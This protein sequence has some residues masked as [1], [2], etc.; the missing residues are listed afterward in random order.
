MI[1]RVGDLGFQLSLD[2]IARLTLDRLGRQLFES[3][4]VRQG[5]S[6]EVFGRACPGIGG[7]TDGMAIRLGDVA[8]C[9]AGQ[10]VREMGRDHVT[11]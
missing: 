3:F 10:P 6:G 4:E 5:N 8:D 7:G 11:H 1:A 2:R 9:P